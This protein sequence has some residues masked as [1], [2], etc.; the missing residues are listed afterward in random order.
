MMSGFQYD[1]MRINVSLAGIELLG[2]SMD[3]KLIST[4]HW[5]AMAS[6]RYHSAR[7]KPCHEWTKRNFIY[8]PDL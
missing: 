1:K 5:R 2:M 7:E 4:L 6:R 3:L 8:D